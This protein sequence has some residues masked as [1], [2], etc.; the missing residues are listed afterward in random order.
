[1]FLLL[2][3]RG[4]GLDSTAFT[5]RLFQ[6]YGVAVMDGLAFGEQTRGFVRLSFAIDETA[7][8][9]ACRRIRVF[10]EGLAGEAQRTVRSR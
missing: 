1:M 8:V 2:D 4:T 10:C 6:A 7:I 5:A 9:E 3:I